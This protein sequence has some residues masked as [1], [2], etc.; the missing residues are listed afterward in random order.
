M[1]G[2]F[3]GRRMLDSREA[4]PTEIPCNIAAF[5]TAFPDAHITVEDLFGDA[6]RAAARWR[7]AATQIR[8][9]WVAFDPAPFSS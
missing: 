7:F 2:G 6:E 3:A 1:A 4:T 5:R 9:V 8:V